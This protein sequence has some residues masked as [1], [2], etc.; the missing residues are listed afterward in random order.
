[1][2]PA[3]LTSALDGG[4]WSASRPCRF[5]PEESAPATHWIGDW[6]GPRFGLED[7]EKRKTLLRRQSNPGPPDRSESLYHA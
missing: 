1:M 3:F 2:A 5:T 4:K 6:V 7:V